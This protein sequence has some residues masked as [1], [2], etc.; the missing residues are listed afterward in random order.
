MRLPA[1]MSI[2]AAIFAISAARADHHGMKP[3]VG[4]AEFEKIKNLA[5]KW[6][7]TMPMPEGEMTK[8]LVLD[9]GSGWIL[10]QHLLDPQGQLIATA[11]SSKHLRDPVSGATL[12]RR[13]EIR[14]PS[15]HHYRPTV[16]SLP[17]RTLAK[18]YGTLRA[19]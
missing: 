9:A 13:T 2:V 16:T 6:T 11:I 1:I 7:G 18:A 8:V 4:S 19:E 17:L 10:E 3:Y 5:G 15:G 12:P 14:W